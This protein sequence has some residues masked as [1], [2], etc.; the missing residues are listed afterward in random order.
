MRGCWIDEGSVA[1]ES[2][3]PRYGVNMP[4]F[5]IR[6]ATTTRQYLAALRGMG[7][8]PAIYAAWNWYPNDDGPEF[9]DRISGFLAERFPATG[10]TFP[11]V[12]VDIETHDVDYILGFLDRWRRLRPA[13]VTA[14][15]LEGFQGGLFN[16]YARQKII[17]A[18]VAIVPQ[19]YKGD[20]TPQPAGVIQDLVAHGFPRQL[21]HGFYDAATVQ[22]PWDGYLF[23]Q[24]RLP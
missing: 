22:E 24:G 5:S 23:T 6:E 1:D 3:L 4:A 21:L 12:C 7:F 8:A 18:K 14:W 15:T 16:E 2:K 19:F 9:A 10:T 11:T 20:M 17:E 13:R